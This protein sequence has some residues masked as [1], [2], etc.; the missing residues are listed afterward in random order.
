MAPMAHMRKRK[1]RK[2]PI[3]TTLL[4]V[5][6]GTGL[7]IFATSATPVH[8]QSAAVNAKAEK[9][10]KVLLAMI[11]YIDNHKLNTGV[12][13]KDYCDTSAINGD[14]IDEIEGCGNKHFDFFYATDFTG[15]IYVGAEGKSEPFSDKDT[16]T[17][18]FV[19]GNNT[20]NSWQATGKLQYV[21][22]N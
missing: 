2:V 17:F 19:K 22:P 6:L 13:P 11:K 20:T 7:L 9:A 4:A 14:W 10:P 21:K 8:S 3:L 12:W 18:Y 16:L 5:T 1:S 15:N